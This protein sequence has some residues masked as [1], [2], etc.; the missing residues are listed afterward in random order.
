MVKV[1]FFLLRSNVRL[2]C[3]LSIDHNDKDRS[4]YILPEYIAV[5]NAVKRWQHVHF[6]RIHCGHQ[7]KTTEKYQVRYVFRYGQ[8][9]LDDLIAKICIII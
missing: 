8:L 7:A 1:L 2:L 6:T 5:G 3:K 4:V 9:G